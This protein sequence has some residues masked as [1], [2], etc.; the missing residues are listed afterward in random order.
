VAFNLIVDPFHLLISS[1]W[2]LG[3]AFVVD[4][5]SKFV[6][7]RALRMD[8]YQYSAGSVVLFPLPPRH[9]PRTVV[10]TLRASMSTIPTESSLKRN[11]LW[12]VHQIPIRPTT[13]TMISH[14]Q[15]LCDQVLDQSGH[16]LFQEEGGSAAKGL[17]LTWITDASWQDACSIRNIHVNPR[18]GSIPTRTDIVSAID[19]K[20]SIWKETFHDSRTGC[21]VDT[22]TEETTL[23]HFSIAYEAFINISYLLTELLLATVGMKKHL[24][25]DGESPHPPHA[26]EIVSVTENG[27]SVDLVIAFSSAQVASYGV[28]VTLDIFTRQYHVNGWMKK[29]KVANTAELKN[30]CT[31]LALY[32]RM[33]QRRLGPYA[34]L[35]DDSWPWVS[36]L[37]LEKYN[38]SGYE[39][40]MERDRDPAQWKPFAETAKNAREEGNLFPL[41]VIHCKKIPYSSLYPQCELITNR[42]LRQEVPV[43]E[44][45]GMKSPLKLVYC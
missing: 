2:S 37:C 27:R 4:P 45:A 29:G 35:P 40:E 14:N 21:I 34:A 31:L 5:N 18:V 3:V 32:W 11:W 16:L 20:D 30:V 39:F 10:Q 24:S 42:N 15:F 6:A 36:S 7:E 41:D 44:L 9:H 22:T 38:Q 23:G 25:T 12:P 26:V 13:T 33:K 1:D 43:L 19:P 28:Y 8:V 17:R